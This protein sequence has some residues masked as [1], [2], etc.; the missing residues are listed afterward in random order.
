[1]ETT[2]KAPWYR[3]WFESPYYDLLYAGRDRRE[4]EGFIRGLM[5]RLSL[6]KETEVLDVGCGT[7]RHSMTLAELGYRVTGIDQSARMI[8]EAIRHSH[9]NPRFLKHDMRDPF[10]FTGFG[11][12][13]NLFNSFGFFDS[14]AEHDRSIGNMADALSS[15]GLLVIDYLNADHV[16]ANLVPDETILRDGV[17][18]HIE[19]RIDGDCIRKKIG[20]LDKGSGDV[21]RFEENVR[22]FR[23]ADF[24]DMLSHG[25]LR[26][27]EVFGDYEW[28][29]FHPSDSPRLVMFAEKP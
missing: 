6:P 4:A 12:V 27:T 25:G 7:G 18:F 3:E 13:L 26:I 16:A 28:N 14:R 2:K 23:L 22:A 1:M 10:P 21:H 29:P 8:E 11:L 5:G 19:R 20:I 15:G 9:G 24:A 17:E